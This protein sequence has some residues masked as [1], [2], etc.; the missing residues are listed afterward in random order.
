MPQNTGAVGETVI[1]LLLSLGAALIAA[2]CM[3]V[4]VTFMSAKFVSGEAGYGAGLTLGPVG[5]LIAG[6]VAFVIVFR[7]MRSF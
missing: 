5:A 2:I 6:V 4:V 1:F 7:K 3:L